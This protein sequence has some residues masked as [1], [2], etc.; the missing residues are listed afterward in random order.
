MLKPTLP[1]Y[2]LAEWRAK[3]FRDR[4]EWVCGAWAIQGYG[5]PLAVYGLYL[6]KIAVYCVVWAWFCTFTPGFRLSEITG[7]WATDVAFHKA[8]VFTMLFEGLGLGCGSGP[9]T[10]RYVPPIGGALYFL[11]PGTTKLPLVRLPVIGGDRRTVLDVVLYGAVIVQLVRIL[12]AP[13]VTPSL[14]VPV[15]IAVPVL[16]LL[17][18]TLFLVFRSEHYLSVLVCLLFADWLPAAK[19]VWLAIWWWAAT[20]KVNR[21]FPAVMCVMVSNSPVMP[22]ALKKQMYRAYPSDLRPSALATRLAHFGTVAEYVFPLVLALAV[23]GPITAIT[24]AFATVF[25]AFILSEVPMGVPLEWNV[26]MVY[27]AWVLFGVHA[28]VR[29]WGI[30]DPALWAWLVGF[31]LALPL[32]GSLYPGRVSFLLAMRYYAGNW[33]YSVW[34]FRG[35]AAEKLD[36]HLVKWSMRVQR[37]LA[38]LYDADT[39]DAL[40]SKVVAF[41][42]MHLH[43][44]ALRDLVPRAVDDIDQYEWLDGEIVA[45]MVVGWNFGEGHLHDLRL[46]RAIQ[47]Q[48]RFEPGELRVI[49]VESQPLHRGT[50]AWTIADA[51]DGVL[52]TGEVVV[53]ELAELQ[54]WPDA[55]SAASTPAPA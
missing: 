14:I 32:Y 52:A 39:I 46:L 43:G 19:V 10:G 51:A 36:R 29:A 26:I 21:H 38:L 35:N 8:I 3:P 20:S 48:C 25:H 4:L 53:A 37:Q 50:Q 45:G 2:D 31:H 22:Q 9:L 55:I 47:T 12:V 11:R 6:A 18:R 33:A 7:W 27:G 16:G 54:P 40:M 30:H 1:P 5:S 13:A 28:D 24:L 23:G 17:D 15:L 34:L 41:R 42:A 44:R 49:L